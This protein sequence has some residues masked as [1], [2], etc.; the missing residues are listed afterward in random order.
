MQQDKVCSCTEYARVRVCAYVQAMAFGQ[1]LTK[2]PRIS[3]TTSTMH[4][5]DQTVPYLLPTFT[6]VKIGWMLYQNPVSP[7]TFDL[8]ID[9]IA[10]DSQ[11]IGCNN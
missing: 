2:L 9:E 4:G 5:G 10:I 6:N 11:R 7:T 8:W 3:S 1:A